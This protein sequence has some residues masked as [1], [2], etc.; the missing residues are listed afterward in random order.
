MKLTPIANALGHRGSFTKS[1]SIN[2]ATTLMLQINLGLQPI[3]RAIN[4]RNITSDIADMWLM[5]S[6]NRPLIVSTK[7]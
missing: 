5:L 1:V 2:L 7:C 4:P 6:V 3:S